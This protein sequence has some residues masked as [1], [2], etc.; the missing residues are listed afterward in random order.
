MAYLTQSISANTSNFF[1]QLGYLCIG[2]FAQLINSVFNHFVVIVVTDIIVV[3]VNLILSA[4]ITFKLT[5]R[6]L[7]VLQLAAV[8]SWNEYLPK[9]Y[10]INLTIEIMLKGM[11]RKLFKSLTYHSQ[12]SEHSSSFSSLN[13]CNLLDFVH[14]LW[15]IPYDYNWFYA[16]VFRTLCLL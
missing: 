2:F 6:P 1:A 3:N 15:A 16:S 4:V 12:V 8:Y 13:C 11:Q 9:I 10:N 14:H 5:K 7:N